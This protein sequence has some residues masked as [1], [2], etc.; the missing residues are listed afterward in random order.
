MKEIICTHLSLVRDSMHTGIGRH[1][2]LCIHIVLSNE[3][4]ACDDIFHR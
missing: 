2:Y 3:V 1:D 4:L